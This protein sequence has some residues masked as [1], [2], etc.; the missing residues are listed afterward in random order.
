MNNRQREKVRVTPGR[1]QYIRDC[2]NYWNP[3]KK[4]F[5]SLLEELKNTTGIW[6]YGVIK[7]VID[8]YGQN[9]YRRRGSKQHKI[10]IT[11]DMKKVLA[12]FDENMSL[13]SMT[14]LF[15][16]YF[17]DHNITPICPKLIKEYRSK[18][19]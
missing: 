9:F 13:T 10:F 17:E 2:Y 3:D 1:I 19:V 7:V 4:S 11:E 14:Y 5:K 18:L 8:V 6:S 15:N 16:F 12:G